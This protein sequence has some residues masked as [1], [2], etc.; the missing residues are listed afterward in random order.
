MPIKPLKVT[1]SRNQFDTRE[2]VRAG[3][4][5]AQLDAIYKSIEA[6]RVIEAALGVQGFEEYEGGKESAGVASFKHHDANAA[7]KAVKALQRAGFPAF[8]ESHGV[9]HAAADIKGVRVSAMIQLLGTMGCR[10][11]ITFGVS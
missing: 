8:R 11:M 7:A 4:L 5:R 9:T 3:E 1:A 6:Y 2:L 10:V